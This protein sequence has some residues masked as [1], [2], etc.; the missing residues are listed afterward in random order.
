MKGMPL[1]A[2]EQGLAARAKQRLFVG[3]VEIVTDC[4][5]DASA[6]MSALTKKRQLRH[7]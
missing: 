5:R 2:R 3:V 4:R 6:V 7:G 1:E